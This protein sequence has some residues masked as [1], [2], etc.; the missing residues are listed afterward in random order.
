[1]RSS[2]TDCHWPGE[3]PGSIRRLSSSTSIVV[4]APTTSVPR[5]RC[6]ETWIRSCQRSWPAQLAG[7]SSVGSS[8]ASS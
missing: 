7:R 6:T 8:L 2:P 1:M 5:M 4:P 3:M